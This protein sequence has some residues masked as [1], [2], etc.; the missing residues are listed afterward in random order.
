MIDSRTAYVIGNLWLVLSFVLPER[1][2][3]VVHGGVLLVATLWIVLGAY[4]GL[5][6]IKHGAGSE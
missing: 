6:A 4:M 5:H 2:D 3:W 1:A